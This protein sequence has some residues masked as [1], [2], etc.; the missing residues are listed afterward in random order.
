[1]R[2]G[3]RQPQQRAHVP[4]R[5]EN[6]HAAHL[7]GA[8]GCWTAAAVALVE[9]AR[10]ERAADEERGV[11]QVDRPCRSIPTQDQASKLPHLGRPSPEAPPR[12][13]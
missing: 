7:L 1:M 2:D 3:V 9:Q 12:R 4:R 13:R 6:S 8:L 10:L 11:R 5:R